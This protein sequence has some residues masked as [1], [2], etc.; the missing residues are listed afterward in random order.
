MEAVGM[1]AKGILL[2]QTVSP[3]DALTVNRLA[4]QLDI[5]PRLARVV[6]YEAHNQRL[7]EPTADFMSW[8]RL[9][10]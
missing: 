6:L 1:L 5:D 9:A 2:V 4:T 3:G 7:V 8:V 10:P